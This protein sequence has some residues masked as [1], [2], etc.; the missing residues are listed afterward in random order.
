MYRP[1]RSY[2]SAALL[3]TI[4]SQYNIGPRNHVIGGIDIRQTRTNEEKQ[5]HIKQKMNEKLEIRPFISI[6]HTCN[7]SC[8]LWWSCVHETDPNSIMIIQTTKG[9]VRYYLYLKQVEKC[10]DGFKW[11]MKDRG[12]NWMNESIVGNS[13]DFLVSNQLYLLPFITT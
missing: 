1:S 5:Q 2:R 8:R 9:G 11:K 3:V 6:G 13:T 7:T 12:K 4:V 10:D